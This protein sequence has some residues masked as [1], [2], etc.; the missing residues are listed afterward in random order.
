MDETQR[1]KWDIGRFMGTLKYFGVV[2]FFGSISW[3]QQL[4]GDKSKNSAT[5]EPEVILVAGATGGV[6]KRVVKR[7]QQRGQNVRALVRDAGRARTILG[8]QVELVEGDITIAKTLTPQVMQN[9]V[10]I[11]CCTGTKVQPV[12]G[13]TPNREKYYQ[14]IKFYMPEV[15]DVPEIVEYQGL[16]NLVNL[17]PA[18]LKNSNVKVIFDFTKP[19]PD[20]KEIWG[21]L[22]DVVMGG[23]SESSLQLIGNSA[24]FMGNV[25][26][27][28][29]GGFARFGLRALI[30]RWIYPIIKVLIC[31]LREMV[32]AISL[33]FVAM[34]SG[35]V[36]P[37]AILL[38]RFIIFP[39]LF[40]FPLIS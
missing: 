23:V 40:E 37:I 38:T 11:I 27:A 2:P 34:K 10:A 9:V 35:I 7:L 31:G 17:A 30:R 19:S 29:S 3:L 14:G 28:N 26:T 33:L 32:N 8:N 15:V 1:Q 21:A 16:Q 24:F 5:A 22:D 20:L 4:L 36:L 12:E 13:D 39:L 6:G 18:S 25:S